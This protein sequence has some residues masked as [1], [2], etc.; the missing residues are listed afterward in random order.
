ME[1]GRASGHDRMAICGDCRTVIEES[2]LDASRMQAKLDYV[3]IDQLV[4]Y[5]GKKVR[6]PLCGHAWR[7]FPPSNTSRAPQI[8]L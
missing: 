8:V 2:D 1:D 4:N 3:S 6:G 5:I 7:R